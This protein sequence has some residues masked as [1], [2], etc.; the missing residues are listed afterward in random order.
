MDSHPQ[1]PPHPHVEGSD[2]GLQE[3]V[4]FGRGTSSVGKDGAVSKNKELDSHL[5][6]SWFGEA[7]EIEKHKI[8]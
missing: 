3:V 5:T 1:L 6:D 7:Q 2:A 8:L 4:P